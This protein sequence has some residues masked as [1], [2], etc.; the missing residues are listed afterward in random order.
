MDRFD[1]A[2][3]NLTSDWYKTAA[4]LPGDE[5]LDWL[6]WLNEQIAA[7]L[8]SAVAEENEACEKAVTEF[9]DRAERYRRYWETADE[10]AHDAIRARRKP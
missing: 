8:R 4:C 7:A 1:H 2:A 10:L 9:Y 5:P 6:D 3:Q